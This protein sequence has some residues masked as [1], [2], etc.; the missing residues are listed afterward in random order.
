[1]ILEQRINNNVVL[2]NDHGQRSIIMGK[3][4]GF[5]SYPGDIVERARI[6]KQFYAPENMSVPQV[7]ATLMKVSTA[8]IEVVDDIISM[9]KNKF[10]ELEESLFFSMLEHINFALKRLSKNSEMTSPLEWEVKKFYPV[11]YDLGKMAVKKINKKLNVNLPESE[12]FFLAL[13]FVNG[14]LN[15]IS[16]DEVFELSELTN[17]IM[18]IIIYFYKIDFDETSISYNRLVTHI[19]YFL[20]RLLNNEKI[21][22]LNPDFI[23]PILNNCPKEVECVE[24]IA[25]FL[26][27]KKNW[28]VTNTDKF[29]LVLNLNKIK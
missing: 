27:K 28:V 11:E 1:M 25:S 22:R 9:V 14:Q 5:Q 10:E 23:D 12:A 26:Q 4:I 6:E 7:A 13:H 18:K 2:V 24:L 16:G 19:K 20:M 8:E 29:Y 21:N 17:E 3:G 15:S